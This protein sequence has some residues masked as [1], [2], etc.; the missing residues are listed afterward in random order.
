MKYKISNGWFHYPNETSQRIE[1]WGILEKHIGKEY[2]RKEMDMLICEMIM[3]HP[4]RV[5]LS[6]HVTVDTVNAE[7]STI[8]S[9]GTRPRKS[10]ETESVDWK[11]ADVLI[12]K[13]FEKYAK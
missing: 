9:A 10:P 5:G 4:L 8:A 7:G 12:D 3:K 13:I 2:G 11:Q 1:N 6:M